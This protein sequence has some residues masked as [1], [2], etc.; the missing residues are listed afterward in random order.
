MKNYIFFLLL[1]TITISQN[2]SGKNIYISSSTNA[3]YRLE[4][5]TCNIELVTTIQNQALDIAF[6][7]NG[8][9]YGISAFGDFYEI[10][11]LTGLTSNLHNFSINS[12]QT[13]NSLTIASDGIV[14]TVGDMGE[15]WSYDIDTDQNNFIGDIGYAATGDLTFYEGNLYAAANDDQI[16][17][18]N[19]DNTINSEVIINQ[20]IQGTIFGIVSFSENC[21]DITS[22]AISDENSRI[23]EIDFDSGTLTQICQL[24]LEVYGGASSFEFFG[25]SPIN[26][27]NIT[28]NDPLCELDNG[29]ITIQASGGFGQI[30]YAIDDQNF[31]TNGTF[32][33]LLEG[34]YDIIISDENG[35][36]ITEDVE[37]NLTPL[38]SITEVSTVDASCGNYDGSITILANGLA[39]FQYSLDGNIFQS[40]SLFNNISNGEYSIV[41][42]DINGCT[43]TSYIQLNDSTAFTIANISIAP[44][45]CGE[46]NG[47]VQVELNGAINEPIIS[48]ENSIGQ[49]GLAL[50][51]LTTG[52]YNI[53]ITDELN[54]SL[55]FSVFIPQ[56]ECPIYIP[57]AFS[58]NK[59]GY[60]DIF[61]IYP[62][63]DFIGEFRILKIFDRWGGQ[64]YEAK[65][66]S[67]EDEGWDGTLNGQ[68]LNAGVYTYFLEY[69]SMGNT[70][71]IIQG[72]ITLLK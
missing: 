22:Y 12:G 28:A 32:N 21:E 26:V 39:P 38:P 60:N 64:L 36:T 63:P 27:E 71:K 43:D 40:D 11:T 7:P 49:P 25:S 65:N 61:K 31:Q 6:H 33:D 2:L 56:E 13:Y 57:N 70:P 17:R 50:E 16:V 51:N 3:L 1:I 18:I 9:L 29:S 48:I 69:L 62:H 68:Q 24:N 10:D 5:E 34:F 55:D 72:D 42:L 53:Q 20:P 45:I 66:F 52:E 23:Y 30:S 44:A 46:S 59:D 14:Y 8:K 58:P 67:P 37:L 15:L 41:L 19:L 54:C 4:I 35:C 47:G